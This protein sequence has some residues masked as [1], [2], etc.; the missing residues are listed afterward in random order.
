MLNSTKNKLITISLALVCVVVILVYI[1]TSRTIDTNLVIPIGYGLSIGFSITLGCGFVSKLF[2]NKSDSDRSPIDNYTLLVVS[3]ALFILLDVILINLF[4]VKVLQLSRTSFMS[5]LAPST[6]KAS[7][8]AEF[9]IGLTG[10]LLIL[11]KNFSS[12]MRRYYTEIGE[13]KNELSKYKYE[14][15]KNQLNPHFLFNMLNTLSGLIHSDIDKS[16]TFIHHF[17]LLYRYALKVEPEDVVSL[18]QELEFIH[19]FLFLN[20]I[21]FDNAISSNIVVDDKTQYIVPMALQL[22]FENAIKHNKFNKENPLV[23][24]VSN[25]DGYLK[26]SNTKS[27]KENPAPSSN[28]GISILK[29]R[30]ARLSNIQ[31]KIEEDANI[32]TLLL[33]I[34]KSANS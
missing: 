15:L 14:T 10:Y 4:W 31:L 20:N 24:E 17:S 2:L 32:F 25:A 26:I 33:P 27:V 12:A 21:R 18:D 22:A 28:L 5:T 1:Y 11:S 6:L 19:H 34:L 30:Y 16:D 7:V 23:I 13:I 9:A 29:A 8:I 3:I